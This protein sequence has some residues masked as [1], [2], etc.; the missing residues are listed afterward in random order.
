MQ[1]LALETGGED[2]ELSKDRP[3]EQIYASIEEHLRKQYGIGY[4]PARKDG[5]GRYR[6]IRLAT[7]QPG[8]IVQTR[9]G[10]YAE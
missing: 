5:G 1:R 8:L 3:I 7:T 6:K 9:A 4:T 2:F 10:Y